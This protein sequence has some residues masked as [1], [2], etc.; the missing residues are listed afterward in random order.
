MDVT[1]PER[2]EEVS[3][4]SFPDRIAG[5]PADELTEDEAIGHHVI[6]DRLSGRPARPGVLG[7]PDRPLPVGHGERVAQ[8]C[9]ARERHP[10]PMRQHVPDGDRVLAE[11]GILRPVPGDRVV[12]ADRAPLREQVHEQRH[13]RLAHR[14][15][16]EHRVR[17][18]PELT[19]Q[20]HPPVPQHAQLGYRAVSPDQLE[21]LRQ[22]VRLHP[23][24]S[25]LN[26]NP[27][28]TNVRWFLTQD[29]SSP[30]SQ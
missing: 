12:Q 25:R 26:L 19:V 10:G 13:E 11:P 18:A 29:A 24:F 23:G 3:G 30:P 16:E 20:H 6:A 7:L 8:H 28:I 9:A 14:V 27:F 21:H 5:H 15:R 2:A 1:Q 4:E 22:L 17:A